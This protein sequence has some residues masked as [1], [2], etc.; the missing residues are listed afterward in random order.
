MIRTYLFWK[1]KNEFINTLQYWK[2][3]SNKGGTKETNTH[4]DEV[5][6]LN[7]PKYVINVY[8]KFKFLLNDFQLDNIRKAN[9]VNTND[10]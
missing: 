10:K 7:L 1:K 3:T 9:K 6:I 2:E 8:Q 4:C 5:D